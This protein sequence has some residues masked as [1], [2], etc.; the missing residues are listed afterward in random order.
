M[1]DGVM[2]WKLLSLPMTTENE[3]G[4]RVH[5]NPLHGMMGQCIY[6][7][8]NNPNLMYKN[9]IH[10]LSITRKQYTYVPTLAIKY[11]LKIVPNS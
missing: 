7:A 6:I 3:K 5:T 4:E 9:V 1:L 10:N 11:I 8:P 2:L